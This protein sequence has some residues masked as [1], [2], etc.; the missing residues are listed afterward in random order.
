MKGQ[1]TFRILMLVLFLSVASMQIAAQTAAC[2]SPTTSKVAWWTGD[3]TTSDYLNTSHGLNSSPVSF[4]PGEVGAGFAL[5]GL[6]YT[7]LQIP[8]TDA[9]ESMTVAL[10]LQAWVRS[11][12][13]GNF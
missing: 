5:D 13:P 1:S 12:A 10:S 2:V 3:N 9:L 6:Q 4:A 7:Y 11:T 8:R